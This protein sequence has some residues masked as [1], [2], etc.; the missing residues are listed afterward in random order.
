[1]TNLFEN[2][3]NRRV[4]STRDND[5]VDHH[6]VGSVGRAPVTVVGVDV[7]TTNTKVLLVTGEG[8]V[9]RSWSTPTAP[10]LGSLLGDV[11]RG[12]RSVVDGLAAAPRAVGVASMAETGVPLDSA[13]VALTPFV[14]WDRTGS[15]AVLGALVRDL[16]GEALFRATG[17]PPTAKTPLAMWAALR[18]DEPA[19]WRRTARWAGVADAVATHL[20]GESVTDHTLALRTMAVRLPSPGDPAP[21][22]FDPDL[23]QAVGLVPDQLPA[24]GSPDTPAGRLVPAAADRCGLDAGTPVTVAGHDHAVAAWVAGARRPGV[25][26]VSVGTSEALVR[27]AGPAG[28]DRARATGLGMSIARSIAGDREAVLAGSGSGGAMAAWLGEVT[29]G[30]GVRLLADP[31]PDAGGLVVTPYP[32][33]RQTPDPDPTA[34]PR[35]LEPGAAGDRDPRSLP[36]AVLARAVIDGLAGH[37]AWMDRA[38]R[39]LLGLP[40]RADDRI[41]LVGGAAATNRAWTAARSRALGVPVRTLDCPE[42]VA[43]GAALLAGVRAGVLDPDTTIAPIAQET[44]SR[45][46]QET[47]SPI[48]HE[49]TTT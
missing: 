49:R 1:M 28:V 40:T 43:A 36:P 7:G 39:E 26:A 46:V 48:A 25:A 31:A 33:G 23:L 5:V 11:D 37:L 8:R 30:D 14:R 6:E 45:L 15:A 27:I 29:G 35:V 32:R 16:G 47:D 18:R 44:A 3:H 9:L 10:D 38:Q 19:V 22:A 42:P 34:R 12:I 21:T 20:T 4:P 17:V 24:I 41:V 13:G 2:E